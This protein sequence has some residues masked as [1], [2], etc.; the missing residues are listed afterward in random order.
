MYVTKDPLGIS[1]EPSGEIQKEGA[2]T[3]A[4]IFLFFSIS[5]WAGSREANRPNLFPWIHSRPFAV[6]N[7]PTIGSFIFSFDRNSR[8]KLGAP[9]FRFK[10]IL[11]IPSL[12]F[13]S[14]LNKDL[15][16]KRL[17]DRGNISHSFN[18]NLEFGIPQ[19]APPK[20]VSVP[21]PNLSFN[22]HENSL[23]S[24]RR[25]SFPI[26][27]R[28]SGFSQVNLGPSEAWLGDN[29]EACSS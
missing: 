8:L 29:Q 11:D 6:P 26:L 1:I 14:M 23:L 2:K 20:S 27:N 22:N 12:A 3:R 15:M 24:N 5:S 25:L 19:I 21:I 18:A 9:V 17:A 10:E 13:P 16:P 28:T 7:A 4:I